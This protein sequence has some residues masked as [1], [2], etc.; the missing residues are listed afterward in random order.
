MNKVNWK[1]KLEWEFVNNYK[2][3]QQAFLK[4]NIKKYIEVN[5]PN[6][7]SIYFIIL[8]RLKR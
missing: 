6:R 4:C 2:L 5:N 7:N 8:I 1:A 3:L